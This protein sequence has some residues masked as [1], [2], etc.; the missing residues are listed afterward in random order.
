MGLRVIPAVWAAIA[1]C[2]P[3]LV[4]AET[5]TLENCVSI[6]LAN[7]PVIK[8][9]QAGYCAAVDQSQIARSYLGPNVQATVNYTYIDEPRSVDVELLPPGQL[10]DRLV[11]SAAFFE[12]ARQAGGPAAIAALNDLD[13][14]AFQQ[15]EQAVSAGLPSTVS[16]DLLGQNFV[17]SQISM[18]QP[19][20]T[21]GK[22][23]SR[24]QQAQAAACIAA[25]NVNS[26]KNEIAYGISQ[27]YY[28][29]VLSGLLSRVSREAS[30]YAGGVEAMAD[31]LVKDGD[32]YVTTADVSRAQT[33]RALYDEQAVGMVV[34]RDRALTGLKLAMGLPQE[35]NIDVTAL[36]LP[37]EEVAFDLN[38]L[39][40]QAVAC[41]PDLKKID[42]AYE[43]ATLE[44]KIRKA[45]FL[46]N[47]AAFATYSTI[48]DDQ[49]FLNPNDPAEW[50]LGVTATVPVFQSGR[51]VSQVRQA[52]HQITEV[53]EQRRFLR[54]AVEQQ[55]QDAFLELEEM[56]RRT[57]ETLVAL[58]SA[59]ESESNLRAQYEAGLVDP[60]GMSKYYEDL[61]TARLL[62]VTSQVR[63]LQ[64][65]F[66]YNVALAK[67]KLAVGVDPRAP[68][69]GEVTHEAVPTAITGD[70]A[71]RGRAGVFR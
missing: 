49:N 17:T 54:L 56:S 7:H 40:E 48:T 52:N 22:I 3:G 35:A 6:A 46:P 44:R 12:I 64:N 26:S 42:S 66:G 34:A 32:L 61:L 19:L 25:Q 38:V 14:P 4:L 27:A 68:E 20:Y 55:V 47:V 45:E 63:Y 9:R 67:L 30:G 23:T 2:G 33:F 50:A 41:R 39:K 58:Q 13:G 10:R 69:T 59:V 36:E 57:R 51:R 16:V 24:Y 21:A 1:A 53:N 31:A 29:V 70:T 37:P 11:E 71:H 15:A 18:I 28:T 8:S 65:R 60:E 5:L 43:I 62:L